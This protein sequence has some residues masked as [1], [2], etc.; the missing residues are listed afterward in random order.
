MQATKHGLRS[1]QQG[2][3]HA[4]SHANTIL[5]CI[6]LLWIPFPNFESTSPD[7]NDNMIEDVPK[8]LPWI[9]FDI[10]FMIVTFKC[11]QMKIL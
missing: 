2:L 7:R 6:F 9:I 11:L 10:T 8:C 1:L 4:C 5:P 3:A